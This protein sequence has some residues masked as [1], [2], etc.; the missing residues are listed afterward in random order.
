MAKLSRNALKGLVKECL[1]EI[2]SEGLLAESDSKSSLS[3]SVSSVRKKSSKPARSRRPALDNIVMREQ[4]KPRAPVVPEVQDPIMREIFADTAANT[5]QQQVMAESKG[6]MAQRITH[7]DPA[8]KA[9]AE[10]DPMDIF[11][12]S[13]NWAALA[14]DK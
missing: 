12:G 7:G 9:M 1:V 4:K 10:S 3:E 11:E 8:T 6:S 2:L 13:Q 14:F 5:F